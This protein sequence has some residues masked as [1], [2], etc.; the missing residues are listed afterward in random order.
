VGSEPVR[1]PGRTGS[2]GNRSNRTG[3]HRFANPAHHPSPPLTVVASPLEKPMWNPSQ[4]SSPSA[5][6]RNSGRRHSSPLPVS[7]SM[8]S[9]RSPLSPVPLHRSGKGPPP[10]EPA[11]GWRARPTLIR[12]QNARFNGGVTDSGHAPASSL[13]GEAGRWATG[14]LPSSGCTSCSSLSARRPADGGWLGHGGDVSHGEAAEEWV[15]RR[16]ETQFCLPVRARGKMHH[17]YASSVSGRKNTA[18]D[19]KW[20][21]VLAKTNHHYTNTATRSCTHQT[22]NRFFFLKR[23]ERQI[24][25]IIWII[26][27]YYQ[28]VG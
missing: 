7:P 14:L 11:A 21:T 16:E 20:S 28:T 2:T 12:R 25:I 6:G 24:I 10:G 9:S 4:P 17:L 13:G 26:N 3:S 1:V 23:S 27:L 8:K 5:A 19:P 15:A 22:N 18:R